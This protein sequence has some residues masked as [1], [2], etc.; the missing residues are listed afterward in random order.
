MFI[1]FYRSEAVSANSWRSK[2]EMIVGNF[3]RKSLSAMGKT[4]LAMGCLAVILF[5]WV[6]ISY[7]RAQP[8]NVE[9]DEAII[10]VGSLKKYVSNEKQSVLWS[11]GRNLILINAS[12]IYDFETQEKI[13]NETKT[14]LNKY[15]F[16]GKVNVIFSPERK[17]KETR[18]NGLVVS[19]LIDEKL[20]REV[21]INNT[22]G[23][24]NDRF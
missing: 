4:L 19:E 23:D 13:I 5:L 22:Y 17:F 7:N 11:A 9:I 20:L 2:M 16:S 21:E 10:L 3:W 6:T 12:G 15:P 24:R 18:I 8:S 14:T 1:N